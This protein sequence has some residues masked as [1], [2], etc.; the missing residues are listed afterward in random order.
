MGI[1]L[2]STLPMLPSLLEQNSNKEVKEKL[3]KRQKQQKYYYDKTAKQLPPLKPNDVV[4]FKHKS[5]WKPAVVIG[6]HSSPRSYTIRMTDGTVI[7]RNRRH[8][9]KTDE[10]RSPSESYWY[11]EDQDSSSSTL[12][13]QQQVV[14]PQTMDGMSNTSTTVPVPPP[15]ERRS[16]YGRIIRPPVRY[17][18]ES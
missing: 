8:L 6:I 11:E 16:R 17:G 1:R 15:V 13:Q 7:R 3:H 9:K 2:Q 10:Q 18:D 14:L 5:Y 4:R 12:S